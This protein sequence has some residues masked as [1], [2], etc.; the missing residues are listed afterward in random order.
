MSQSGTVK[1]WKP[2]GFGFISTATGED[3]FVHISQVNPGE[4]GGKREHLNIRENVTFDVGEDERTG[5]ARAINVTGDGSGEEPDMSDNRGGSY[6][7]N[8]GSGGYNNR[9]GSYNNSGGYNNNNSG[10][11][12]GGYGDNS[13]GGF[14][15]Q[16]GGF[17][18]RQSGGFGGGYNNRSGGGRNVCFNFQRT[19]D[20]SYGDSCRF[21]HERQ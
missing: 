15:R 4:D 16:G 3:L 14:G 12:G 2:R 19:G 5:K 20:C 18:G 10:G 7:N 13:G 21:L 9:G 8:R 17:G 1:N 6:S 11:F